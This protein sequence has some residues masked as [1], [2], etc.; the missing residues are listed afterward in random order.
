[1]KKFFNLMLIT[2]S[3]LIVTSLSGCYKIVLDATDSDIPISLNDD[4]SGKIIDNFEIEIKSHHIIY[5]LV[6]LN[7]PEIQRAI[8]K[9]VKNVGGKKAINV[10][11]THEHSFIDGLIN[12]IT[13]GLYNPTSITIEGDIVY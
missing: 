12:I 2:L 10:V 9:K 4:K 6:T 11:I 8:T 5:G 3:L 1:M 7:D 13:A